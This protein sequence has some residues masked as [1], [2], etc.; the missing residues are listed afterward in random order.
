MTVGTSKRKMGKIERKKAQVHQKFTQRKEGI[1]EHRGDADKRAQ[2]NMLSA[3]RVGWT[4]VQVLTGED[5]IN[6]YCRRPVIVEDFN[7]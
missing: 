2:G 5:T 4:R 7:G 3:Q 1:G 6:R